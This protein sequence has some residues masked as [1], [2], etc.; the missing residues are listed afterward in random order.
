MSFR[1]QSRY[2]RLNQ[3]YNRLYKNYEGKLLKLV[4]YL[5]K[6]NST[7]TFRFLAACIRGNLDKIRLGMRD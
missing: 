5:I 7:E 1:K 6:V 2:G 4:K 3:N